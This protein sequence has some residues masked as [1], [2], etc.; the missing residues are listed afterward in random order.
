MTSSTPAAVTDHNS[1]EAARLRIDV[2]S[3]VVC[4]WCYIGKRRLESALAASDHDPDDYEIVFHS[5]QLDPAA[6]LEYPMSMAEHLGAKYGGGA[7]AGRQMMERVEAVAAEEGLLFAL[8]RARS[9]NTRDA[10]RLLHLALDEGGHRV[11]S[12]LKEELLASYFLRGE[13]VSDPAVLTGAALLA[14]LGEERVREVLASTEYDDA[15][16]ADVRQAAAFGATG[17]PFF[18]VDQRYG[19]SGAQ[20]T[21]VFGQVLRRAWSD[22]VPALTVVDGEAVDACGADGCA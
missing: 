15:V 21:E 10:H 1:T 22:R 11:Q 5:F 16:E 2:W 13:L 18:V 4:P 8:E 12:A 14:G 3:D 6:P 20:S 17:V 9:G 19:V 7:A